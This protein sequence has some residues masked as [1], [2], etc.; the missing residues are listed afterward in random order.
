M[1]MSQ[2]RG[3]RTKLDPLPSR[4][5]RSYRRLG[6]H[7]GHPPGKRHAQPSNNAQTQRADRSKCYPELW[8]SAA[9]LYPLNLDNFERETNLDPGTLRTVGQGSTETDR[10]LCLAHVPNQPLE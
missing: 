1:L 6:V 7:Q 2:Y 10:A 4:Q 9:N 5:L 3:P 8:H